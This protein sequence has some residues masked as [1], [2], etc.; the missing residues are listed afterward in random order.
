[1]AEGYRLG[2]LGGTGYC[3]AGSGPALVL[4]HGVGMHAGFWA[5]QM[6][7]FA[8]H[9]DV[10]AY[11]T[12]GH[13]SSLLPPDKPDLG[14]YAGQLL[15]L[16]DGLGLKRVSLVGHSMGALIA[17][18]F[19][20]AF[21]DRVNAVVPM[22]GVYCRTPSQ[23]AAVQ[24]R[25]EALQGRAQDLAWRQAAIDRWFGV[26][27]P[28]VLLETAAWVGASLATVN[29]V[30][31][32]RAYG[33]FARAD[34]AHE[35]QLGRLAMPALFLTGEEDENSSPEMSR[36]MAKAAPQGRALALSGQRHMMSLA[37]PELVNEVLT[38][39]FAETALLQAAQ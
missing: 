15:A 26:P 35:G 2:R 24:A 23:R 37:A 39:F 1:M 16:L 3:R 13:G 28:P 6:A 38:R 8:P 21:P 14:D 9:W 19:A 5:P 18:E 20:L 7:A 34:A 36:R 30:G 33:L 27:V 32:A 29:P 12:L 25:A 31:Y 22:N 4:I 11:D 17:L 10:I